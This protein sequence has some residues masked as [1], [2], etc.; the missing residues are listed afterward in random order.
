M[1]ISG[2]DFPGP[3]LDALCD[4]KLVVFA[5]AGVSMGEPA[6]LPDFKQLAREVAKDTGGV[7]RS[8]E[9]V[10]QFL[11]RLK[12][13]GVKVH[14]RAARALSENNPEP[15]DLHRDLLS[16]Y[17]EKQSIRIVTTNFD[18]LFEQAAKELPG[19]TPEVFRA[20]ALPLGRD[21]NGIVH[22]HGAV[23]HPS[24]MVLTDADFGRAYLT[25]G[26]ARRFLVDLFRSF[27]V[28]FVGY[29]HDDVVMTYLAR[30][31]PVRE[32]SRFAL[33]DKDEGKWCSLGI[34]PITYP[35]SLD[36]KTLYEG[37]HGLADYAARG[38]LDWTREITE[39]ARNPPSLD[40]EKIDLIQDALFDAEKT[41][42]F[43][44]AASSPEW[45]D[46]LDER[47]HLDGLFGVGELSEIARELARWLAHQF[48]L[49]YAD[50][51]FLLIR[52]HGMR[53]HPDFW[54][55]LCHEICR[56]KAPSL[57]AK[58]L[59]R[60]VSLLLEAA[61]RNPFDYALHH[62]GKRCIK[63]DAMDSLLEIFQA[64]AASR[65][66]IMPVPD[67]PWSD[68]DAEGGRSP[69]YLKLNSI[70][71]FSELEEI[72]KEGLK[73]NLGRVAEPL[74]A[75]IVENLAAR[76]RKLLAWEEATRDDDTE[77]FSRSAIEDHKQN[78]YH[79][80]IAVLIDAARDC[81]EWL[82]SNSPEATAGWCERLIGSEAPLLRRLAVHT[83]SER[84]DLE[85]D[86][87]M[88]WLLPRMNLHDLSTH[89]EVFRL[90][91]RAYPD[92][93][94][95]RRKAV[96][97]AILAYRWPREEDENK[98][99]WTA[100]HHFRWLDW[101]GRAAPD[102]ALVNKARN[103]ILERYPD[104]QPG[105]H[106]DFMCWSSGAQWVSTQSP[107]TVEELLARPAKEWV[108]ELLSFQPKPM[109]FDGPDR[110]RFRSAIEDAAQR[111][112]KWGIALAD[113]LKKRGQWGSDPWWVL[114]NAWRS[115]LTG[116]RAKGWDE[117]ELRK[118]LD[119]LCRSELYQKDAYQV[120]CVL[121]ALVRGGVPDAS[122]LLPQ[123][124]GI[125]RKLWKRIDR[126]GPFDTPFDWFDRAINHS[127]GTLADFWL[128]SLSVWLKQQ[129]PRPSVLSDEYRAALS[130]IVQDE[131]FAGKLGRS[132][133][134]NRI[135]FM[136]TVDEG[137]TKENLLPLFEKYDDA[138]GYQAVW[139][140]LL[141]G[142][143][144]DPAVELMKS[145]F[146]K[147]VSRIKSDKFIKYYTYVLTYFRVDEPLEVWI[148]EFF[149]HA[150]E[151]GR[152]SFARHIGN[153]FMGMKEE[154]KRKL[155]NRWLKCYWQNRLEGVP[156]PLDSGE[157]GE[158]FGWM[159]YFTGDLF[160]EAVALAV[161][162]DRKLLPESFLIPEINDS[163]LPQ[164][165]PEAVAKLLIHLGGRES[166]FH[167]PEV[168]ELIAKLTDS[169][170]PADLKEKLEELRA[171]L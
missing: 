159:P 99:K 107:W 51:L 35:S 29:S 148:P 49:D 21:F 108:D 92:F 28:L 5:G 78:T 18:S 141:F 69:I 97:E 136:L 150:D 4:G 7:L 44:S 54:H 53:L 105:E 13:K 165:H 27:I 14:K 45:I 168:L 86:E 76:H 75:G 50:A 91:K 40:E 67:R 63:A 156:V 38:V 134:A 61:P 112:I 30:A 33:T 17:S 80:S 82:A 23:T 115:T 167:I 2:V 22:V 48:A 71:G 140:G 36:H 130:A 81:L 56:Q 117:R 119:L 129:D 88:D 101:L 171:R 25:E 84:E 121:E 37:V 137:W 103:A 11:G 142:R 64:M 128:G 65:L 41:R 74:L 8:G 138:D 152:R 126:N 34:E 169:D 1:K 94:S 131:S 58:K 47:E 39:I 160:P 157:V 116:D 104:F 161:C 118:M 72:W 87:K 110:M 146:R 55:Q 12:N 60:W 163:D 98:E 70:G 24:G 3:L 19:P 164:D 143:L 109:D 96:V 162:V 89:H 135:S 26:W 15:T 85:P 106:P 125:A 10:D 16:L 68:D 79:E 114:M 77:S 120:A 62:L 155:W 93:D 147:A 59:S 6:N 153:H 127:A 57:D 73:P 154:R 31:L 145:A 32:E 149:N 95:E 113:E 132:V 111:N 123:A 9:S 42:F 100:H 102:C 52:R 20:P 66:D 144:S 43:K 83:L 124:N 158:M 170:I 151:E 122:N 166:P 46:W 139:D 133:L 90:L